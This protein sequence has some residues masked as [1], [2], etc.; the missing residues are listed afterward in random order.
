MVVHR[1]LISPLSV[2]VELR[3]RSVSELNI[4]IYRVMKRKPA[5]PSPRK[6]DF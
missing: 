2:G 4:T 3:A 6:A 5:T 1:L